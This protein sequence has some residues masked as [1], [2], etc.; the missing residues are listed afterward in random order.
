MG[1]GCVAHI[2]YSSVHITVNS[3]PFDVESMVSKIFSYF[4]IYTVRTER[5]KEFCIF[6][7]QEYSKILGHISVRW[8]TLMPAVDRMLEMF[9]ALKLFFLSQQNYPAAL[10]KMFEEPYTELWLHFVHE[11]LILFHDTIKMLEVDE[12]NV[13][14]SAHIMNYLRI[15]L[16]QEEKFVSAAVK[17]I[18]SQLKEK[19]S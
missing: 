5:L 1:V 16:H 3:L 6:V 4:H 7:S 12:W 10:R 8:L 13:F 2:V 14:E 9:C 18:V 17:R 19:G 11:N 15:T